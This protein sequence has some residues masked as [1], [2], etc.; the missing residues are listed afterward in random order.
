MNDWYFVF[1]AEG[2]KI[3]EGA[4]DDYIE[5]N[6]Q[7]NAIDRKIWSEQAKLSPASD[8]LGRWEV[9]FWDRMDLDL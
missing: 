6:K 7:A 1:V 3:I 8:H 5:I 2:E 9:Y 4:G